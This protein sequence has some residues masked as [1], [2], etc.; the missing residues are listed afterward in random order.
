MSLCWTVEFG[1]L[2]LTVFLKRGTCTACGQ[3][4]NLPKGVIWFIST[5]S[6]DS[7]GVKFL[8]SELF[9]WEHRVWYQNRAN[10]PQNSYYLVR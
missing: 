6:S 2:D 4:R 8:I 10:I 3:R 1:I 9:G 5:N 7:S